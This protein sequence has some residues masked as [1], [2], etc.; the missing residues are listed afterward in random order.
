[1]DMPLAM[2]VWNVYR[3]RLLGQYYQVRGIIVIPTL[4]W[5]D[6][7]KYEFCFDGI[8]QGGTV[9]VSTIGVKKNEDSLK[10]WFDG[11]DE[12]I[13]RL[14]PIEILVYGGEIVYNFGDIKTVYYN[15]HIT[16][17]WKEMR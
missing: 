11:M 13:K 16:E 12:A 10:I 9:S 7:N 6:K 3:N 14:K 2:K 17:K 1:M 5:A 15:N 8:E 4:Q